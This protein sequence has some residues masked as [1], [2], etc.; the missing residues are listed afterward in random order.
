SA[1][2]E[3]DLDIEIAGAIA[4]GANIVVYFA[5]N[6]EQG[7]VDA[8]TTAIHDTH[9]HPEVLSISWGAAESEWSS[10]GLQAMDQAFQDAAALGVTVCC[11][12]GDGGTWDGVFDGEAHVDFP[13]SDPYVLGC[14]G[15]RLDVGRNH[16]ITER[17][18]NE[19]PSSATGGGIS[20]VFPLP[21]WQEDANVPPS[22]N[23]QHSGRG[24]PDIAGNADPH[25]GYQ[26][27]ADGR[28]IVVGGTSAVAPLWAALIALINQQTG[29]PLGYLNPL[30]YQHASIFMEN[31]ALHDITDG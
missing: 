13:A 10:A 11:A 30:L 27:R 21:S 22:V 4:P 24:V 5:P 8:I 9:H 14:G 12:S 26:I 23:D 19:G 1:D 3:V 7:F 16:T 25:T 29:K 18:W 17:V 15:T 6:S 2:G 28:N 31:N 20:D